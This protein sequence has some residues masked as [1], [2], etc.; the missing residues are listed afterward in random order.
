MGNPTVTPLQEN[1]H[2]FGFIVFPASGHRH[3]DTNVLGGATK[4]LAGT[5]LGMITTTKVYVPLAPGAS[6]GSQNAAAILGAT[7]N[8]TAANKNAAMV[9][10]DCEVNASEL[11]WG[12]ATAPQIV[13]ATLQ[14]KALGII[15][16]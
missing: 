3:I 13:A 14:L 11:I 7:K 6:D 15:P 9:V 16:R 5:V 1:W 12:A 8:V 2:D 4:V 10:R